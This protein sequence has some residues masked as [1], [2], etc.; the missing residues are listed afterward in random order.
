MSIQTLPLYSDS[1]II[2]A[3]RTALCWPFILAVRV[4]LLLACSKPGPT[5]VARVPWFSQFGSSAMDI[6]DGVT[7]DGDGNTSEVSQCTSVA[8]AWAQGAMR[9]TS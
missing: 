4:L 6:T 8:A 1:T 5:P 2:G 7:V 3:M 9:R